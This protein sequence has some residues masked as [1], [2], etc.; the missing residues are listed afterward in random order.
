MEA[1]KKNITM[2]IAWLGGLALALGTFT[3]SA[4]SPASLTSGRAKYVFLFIGDGMAMPQ[5]SSAE[6]YAE[7]MTSKAIAVKRLSFTQF[8]VPGLTTTYDAGSFV[9]DS[10]SAGTALA[11]GHKTLNGV[12]NMDPAKTRTCKTLAQYAHEKGM[13]V[14]IVTTVSLDHATP[15]CFHAKT[16]SR[17]N[18]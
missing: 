11:T 6:V 10:A 4:A 15:A 3:A 12:I 18:Y 5:I 13:K 1:G 17:G 2:P 14:G 8:P 9:T 7:A 16:P